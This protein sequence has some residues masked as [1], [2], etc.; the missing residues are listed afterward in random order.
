[1]NECWM[2]DN[3][4]HGKFIENSKH[5]LCIHTWHRRFGQR[6]PNTVKMLFE[7]DLVMGQKLKA[8]NK[9]MKCECCIGT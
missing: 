5:D 8:C 9:L 4:F 7:N 6:D 3:D 2:K 1:M